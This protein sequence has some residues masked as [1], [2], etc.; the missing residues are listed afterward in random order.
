M[1]KKC[2]TRPLVMMA[3]VFRAGSVSPAAATVQGELEAVLSHLCRQEIQLNGTSRTDAGVHRTG[4]ESFFQRK[5]R[6]SLWS[7]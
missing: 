5:F 7:G 3:P 4:S 2:P 1:E 6:D